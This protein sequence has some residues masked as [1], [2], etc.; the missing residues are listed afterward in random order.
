MS[1]K[2]THDDTVMGPLSSLMYFHSSQALPILQSEEYTVN[3]PW[4]F[5]ITPVVTAT[6]AI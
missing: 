2:L 3:P 6:R 5:L 1:Q 4:T